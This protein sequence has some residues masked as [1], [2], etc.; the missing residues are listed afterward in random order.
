MQHPCYV[1]V[2]TI[3]YL[4]PRKN[5]IAVKLDRRYISCLRDIARF[6]PRLGLTVLPE[7]VSL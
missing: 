7:C 1:M 2:F 4:R 3:I 5:I 6:Y